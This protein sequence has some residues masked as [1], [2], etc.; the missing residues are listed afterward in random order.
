MSGVI[1]HYILV[2]LEYIHIIL[3]HIVISYAVLDSGY[4]S[5]LGV[6]QSGVASSLTQ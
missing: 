1:I 6:I 3:Q 2:I 5:K 4:P